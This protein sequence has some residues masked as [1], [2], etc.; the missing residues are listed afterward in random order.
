MDRWMEWGAIKMWAGELNWHR[1]RNE[2]EDTADAK[3]LMNYLGCLLINRFSGV[4]SW[5]EWLL[6]E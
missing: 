1:Q 3:E 2:R 6:M 4:S 5:E